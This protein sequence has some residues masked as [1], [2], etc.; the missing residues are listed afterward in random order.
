MESTMSKRN[1]NRGNDDVRNPVQDR[2]RADP[3]TNAESRGNAR[4]ARGNTARGSDANA[5]GPKDDRNR[6]QARGNR[7]SNPDGM[8]EPL[9]GVGGGRKG[10][11]QH[12]KGIGNNRSGSRSGN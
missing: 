7:A 8:N 9:G 10:A 12:R 4:E 1:K 3:D 5:A 11:P 2:M 6:N